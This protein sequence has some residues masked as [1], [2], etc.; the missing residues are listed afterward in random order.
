MT[1][2]YDD[3][4]LIAVERRTGH[5]DAPTT[6]NGAVRERIWRIRSGRVVLATGAHERPI[7][8]AGNDV[9]GVML[10]ESVRV[11]LQRYGVL[12]GEQVVLFTAHDDAYRVAGELMAVGAV[13]GRRRSADATSTRSPTRIPS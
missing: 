6:T 13:R 5:Q 1:G 10:A 8:F 7:V 4:F 3:N 2:Y 9:P 12:A 11:Y